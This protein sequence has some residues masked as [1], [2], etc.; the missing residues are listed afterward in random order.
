MYG[1]NNLLYNKLNKN[2]EATI[3][4]LMYYV[5]YMHYKQNIHVYTILYMF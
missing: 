3:E 4:Q 5:I 1:N 2:T